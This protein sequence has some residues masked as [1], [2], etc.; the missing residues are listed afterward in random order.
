M[1]G[2]SLFCYNGLH[3]I[4][5]AMGVFLC[6]SMSLVAPGSSL[7]STPMTRR[8]HGVV[9]SAVTAPSQETTSLA[10]AASDSRAIILSTTERARTVTY[11]AKSGTLCT[12]AK[13]DDTELDGSPFGSHVDY[14]LD[15]QGWPTF[16]LAEASLHTENI[17]ANNRVSLLCQTPREDNGQQQA[18][19]ARVTLVGT[20]V[21]VEDYDELI[22]LKASFS[23]VHTYA[24]Q[25]TQ[26]P[27]FK[28]YKLKPHKVYYVGG[29]GVLSKW[30]PVSEYETATPDILA[31]EASSI[32]SKINKTQQEDLMNVCKH[33]LQRAMP[34]TVT[35]TTVDRLGL[36][37]RVKARQLTDEFRIG[38]RQQVS[39]V[40][41]AKSEIVKIFQEAWE[42]ENGYEWEDQGPPTQRYAEDILRR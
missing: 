26:S 36:D 6:P 25:L 34:E 9:L 11:V 4:E 5:K 19:L 33:F 18:A 42:K 1:A 3:I 27:R 37:L 32:V 2:W 28:F 31:D 15:Q 16:L 40:E 12:F 22:Q 35:V 29:F 8:R 10:D 23:L 14:V 38:F 13:S 17:K 7:R 39:S 24:D 41:D 20:I 30:L 21:D